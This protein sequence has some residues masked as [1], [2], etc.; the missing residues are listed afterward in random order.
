MGFYNNINIV[1]NLRSIFKM[2]LNG[3]T[4][5]LNCHYRCNINN[6]SAYDSIGSQKIIQYCN[7]WERCNLMRQKEFILTI[8]SLF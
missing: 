3:A 4:S 1:W 2:E 5:K 7:S 8:M 6:Y